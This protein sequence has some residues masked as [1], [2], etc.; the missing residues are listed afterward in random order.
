MKPIL[1]L[2]LDISKSLHVNIFE[3]RE[4][5]KLTETAE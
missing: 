4:T 3:D 2:V 1:A 5:Q